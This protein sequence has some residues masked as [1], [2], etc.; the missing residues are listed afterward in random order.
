MRAIISHQP[1][2]TA[3]GSCMAGR[4]RV[5]APPALF[6]PARALRAG[7]SRRA[8]EPGAGG[9]PRSCGAVVRYRNGEEDEGSATEEEQRFAG[10]AGQGES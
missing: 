10:A 9:R 1:L 7:G 3:A 2:Y 6:K 8:P 4:R 5:A